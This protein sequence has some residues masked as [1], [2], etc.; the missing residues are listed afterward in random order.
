MMIQAKRGADIPV[1][2]WE[3]E[4]GWKT[5]PPARETDK[6]LRAILEKTGV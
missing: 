6:A 3:K 1:R 5:H 2:H 4:A